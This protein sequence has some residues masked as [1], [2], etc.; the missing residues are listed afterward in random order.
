MAEVLVRSEVL[1]DASTALR[2]ATGKAHVS[3]PAAMRQVFGAGYGRTEQQP[4]FRSSPNSALVMPAAAVVQLLLWPGSFPATPAGFYGSAVTPGLRAGPAAP[5]LGGF[6]ALPVAFLFPRVAV[7]TA[8]DN[9]SHFSW[10]P[11]SRSRLS[12]EQCP[13]PSVAFVPWELHSTPQALQLRDSSLSGA[14]AS[15]KQHA[16]E[17]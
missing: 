7:S 13:P 3:H 5:Q 15:K 10:V 17:R 16:G 4:A 2:A 11:P 9:S 1:H 8:T 6:N 12:G 14:A